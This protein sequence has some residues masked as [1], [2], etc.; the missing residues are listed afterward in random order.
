[1]AGD[2]QQWRIPVPPEV[3]AELTHSARAALAAGDRLNLATPKPHGLDLTEEF[4]AELSRRLAGSPGFAVVEG[5]PV[6][7][8][9]PR[10]TEMAYWL[11][12]LLLG[13]PVTQ[14]RKADLLGRVE[15]RGADITSP[16]QRGYESSAALPF[17]ADRTDVIGLLCVRPAVSG[18]LSRLVSSKAVHDVLLHERPDLLEELYQPFPNDRRGEEQPG[19]AP[20]SAIPVFSRVGTSFAM[21]YLRRFIEGSQRHP[22]APRLTEGQLAAMAALDEVLDR[23]GVSLDM[24]LRR[25]DLQLINNFHILHARTAFA[26]GGGRGRLLLRLWL[27]FAGS[28]ELPEQYASL[29]GAVAAGSYRGGVWPPGA[30]PAEFGRPVSALG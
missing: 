25:G 12:G 11:F 4:A 14:S 27:A 17:H 6:D 7:A 30:V 22:S 29:Y 16:V 26:D 13:R 20:W 18:G 3:A 19:Q 9:D 1:M 8:E 15:D 28:P 21:R 5:F 2:E 23:P 24:E 10:E